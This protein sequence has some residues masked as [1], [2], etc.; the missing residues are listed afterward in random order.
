MRK[1][2]KKVL[3]FLLLI[4]LTLS[5][6][7]CVS[8]EQA[9]VEINHTSITF[10]ENPDGSLT[11]L[12]LDEDYQYL[13]SNE[14]AIASSIVRY[15]SSEFLVSH[16]E[17]LRIL[18]WETGEQTNL[19]PVN[20][21][22]CEV[23]GAFDNT[24]EMD[25]TRWNPTGLFYHQQS[26]TLYIANYNGH[27]ILIGTV[28]DDEFITEKMIVAPGLVSPENVAVNVA[29]TRIAVADYDGNA[30]FLF[31]GTGN[32]LWKQEV[33]LAHGVEI[34]EDSVYCTSLQNREVIQ[35]NYE[36]TELNRVGHLANQGVN[37]YMWP[38]ALELYNG[39]LL[40]SDAHTGM[41]T[42]LDDELNY[43]TAIGS[44]GPY[45]TNFSYPY[46]VL[47]EE[48]ALY[49]TDTFKSRVLQL[50]FQ[51]NIIKQISQEEPSEMSLSNLE[52]IPS[53]P[54]KTAYLYE[55]CDTI[56][57]SFFNPFF[58]DGDIVGGFSSVWFVKGEEN[59][60]QIDLLDYSPTHR[61]TFSASTPESYSTAE[62][63]ATW[64]GV[65]DAKDY[66]FYLFGS[67]QVGFVLFYEPNYQFGGIVFAG[68]YLVTIDG[69]FY[70]AQTLTLED[71]DI[72][73]I[74][75]DLTDT[76]VQQLGQGKSRYSAYQDTMRQYYQ[77]LPAIGSISSDQFGRWVEEQSTQ[78]ESGQELF[79]KIQDGT[80]NAEAIN[81]YFFQLYAEPDQK[82]TVL[83]NILLRTLCGEP[84]EDAMK[85]VVFQ[86]ADAAQ[87]YPDY[88]LENALDGDPY[89]D[90]VAMLENVSPSFTLDV[91]EN[92]ASIKA[93]MFIWESDSNYAVDYT[94]HFLKNGEELSAVD[95]THQTG[96]A[97]TIFVGNIPADQ[98]SV[99]VHQFVGQNRILLRQI[100]AW[101]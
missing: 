90:Y 19:T 50:D 97:Q 85:P 61:E 59:M 56:P 26:Q 94:I 10:P 52:Y 73:R 66:A 75:S 22:T 34:S 60:Q 37:A 40:V 98:I 1:N 80:A 101:E 63:Y 83:E 69:H 21:D 82:H 91:T 93:V 58:S 81:S 48:N 53:Y 84:A 57:L 67:D 100:Q 9:P 70:D 2:T 17:N 4:A 13:A 39:Q 33:P 12:G 76:F 46:A 99:T 8:N 65:L 7:G 79:G 15:T 3:V 86:A 25:K 35:F 18:N 5:S 47:A 14:N 51:G 54:Y 11:P 89:D 78:S 74:L 32:L 72:A 95:V 38:V 71:E 45:M 64:T 24:I 44:N 41:L 20:L 31:D 42:L 62:F 30:L 29:G 43:I 87:F 55:K 28:S 27:N 36:G 96:P 68:S 88:T 49:I 16:Y 77:T 6:A 23:I 92:D